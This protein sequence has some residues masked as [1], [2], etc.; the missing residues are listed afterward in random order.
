MCNRHLQ[1]AKAR[2]GI[3][4]TCFCCIYKKALIKPWQLSIDCLGFY[5]FMKI[6]FVW[7]CEISL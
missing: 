6:D 7:N 3:Y 1:Q 5:E 2:E 4:C